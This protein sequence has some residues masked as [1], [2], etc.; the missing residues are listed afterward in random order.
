MSS[1]FDSMRSL[2]DDTFNN[3]LITIQNRLFATLRYCFRLKLTVPLVYI[4]IN[5]EKSNSN[6]GIPLAQSRRNCKN[7]LTTD[8]APKMELKRLTQKVQS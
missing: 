1:H 2:T 6:F 5:A 8:F 3:E 7:I 4:K